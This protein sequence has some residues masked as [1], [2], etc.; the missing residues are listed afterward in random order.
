ML[1]NSTLEVQPLNDRLMS[2]L[3]TKR[4][5]RK[6]TLLRGDQ[7]SDMYDNDTPYTVPHI[8]KRAYRPSYYDNDFVDHRFADLTEN[9]QQEEK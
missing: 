2:V 5:G 9:I 7:S 8:I 1:P 4:G 6:A 3:R